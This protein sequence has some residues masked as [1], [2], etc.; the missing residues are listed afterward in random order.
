M[1]TNGRFPGDEGRKST[2]IVNDVHDSRIQ[3]IKLPKNPSRG[4]TR[5]IRLPRTYTLRN[6]IDIPRT[7]SMMKGCYVIMN[8]PCIEIDDTFTTI[9]NVDGLKTSLFTSQKTSLRAM[10][11]L[12]IKRKIP[13]D[14]IF[15]N[16]EVVVN[17]GVLSEPVGSGKTILVLALILYRKIPRV[18]PD[19]TQFEQVTST[20]NTRNTVCMGARAPIC[21]Y[22]SVKY[23]TKNILK[24]TII[25]VGVSVMNQWK[26]AINRFTDLKCIYIGDVRSLRKL[27]TLIETRII[28]EYDIVLV[29]N[30]TVSSAVTLSQDIKLMETGVN[31]TSRIYNIIS[32]MQHIC[33]ARVVI[34]DF[35]TTSLP[36]TSGLVAG[37]FTWYISSTTKIAK[38]NNK[39][40]EFSRTDDLLRHKIYSSN[41]IACNALLFNFANVRSNREYIEHANRMSS[42][43][44]IAHIFRNPHDRMISMI[45]GMN[46]EVAEAINA[47]SYTDAARLA[48]VRTTTTVADIFES[49]LGR[50]F[51]R[52]KTACCVISFI[53]QQS[54]DRLPMSQNP[55]EKDTYTKKD[56]MR[57]RPIEYNY[58]NI[59]HL[60]ETTLVEQKDIKKNSSLPIKR[61]QDNIKDGDCP[62]CSSNLVGESDSDDSDS[63]D[64]KCKEEEK[65]KKGCAIMKCC[66]IVVCAECC[67]KIIF[68][69]THG[70]CPKCRSKI[71]VRHNVI[72]FNRELNM[73][74][75]VIG[76]ITSDPTPNNS[77]TPHKKNYS[78]KVMCILN[79]IRGINNPDKKVIDVNIAGLMKGTHEFVDKTT[80]KPR[81]VLIFANYDDM[82]KKIKV[83]LEDEK[84][85][86]IQLAGTYGEIS[87]YAD[88][89]ND[90]TVPIVLLIN[91]TKHCSGLNLQTA[92]DL[93][94]AH[95]ITDA[96]MESQ[97][98]G[99]GQRIGRTSRLN[100]HYVMYENEYTSFMST[101]RVAN[102]NV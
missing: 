41:N 21:G 25:F 102:I 96:N 52:Y 54:D 9:E 13:I 38:H 5:P 55:D 16:S 86:Y 20:S 83:A 22:I 8:G 11:D 85:N 74:S 65:K 63:E 80:D 45:E 69:T 87:R 97:V 34:D 89:F 58:P 93:V 92:T 72:Y 60:L 23:N 47:E 18:L 12:E 66:S 50:E 76:D 62:I 68:R 37:L 14:E 17:A 98:A 40:N 57:C 43:M 71:D 84:I 79:I 100:I 73:E 67:F 7:S 61:V 24:P 88:M 75:I 49:M 99:R 29:K 42:P 3:L 6:W 39:P 101:R 15:N 1:Y 70:T 26:N 32:N 56:L 33:W 59:K 53:E 94:F 35:D 44:F 19:I 46:A 95:R 48:G 90:S 81:K 36:R 28:N 78:D 51:M 2:I 27:I 10:V 77:N 4:T 91:S 30:G 64:E 82:L 31:T